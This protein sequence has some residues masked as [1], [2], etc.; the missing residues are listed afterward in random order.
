VPRDWILTFAHAA[1]GRRGDVHT[2]N[3]ENEDKVETA[4]KGS[5]TPA[6]R[7]RLK[8]FV[9]F[10]L[11][12]I[13]ERVMIFEKLA[14]QMDWGPRTQA[15]YFACLLSVLKIL[16]METTHQDTLMMRRVQAAQKAAPHWDFDDDS[17][18]LSNERVRLMEGIARQTA[19][20]SPMNAALLT[21]YLAQRMG[22]VIKLELQNIVSIAPDNI[23][24]TFKEG[25]TVGR[26]GPY[27]LMVKDLSPAGVILLNIAR[28][29]R[30]DGLSTGKIFF[31]HSEETFKKQLGKVDVRALRRTGLMKLGSVGASQEEMLHVS[32][33]SSV[34]MLNLYLHNG[35][36]NMKINLSTAEKL[37]EAMVTPLPF[38]GKLCEATNCTE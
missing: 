9:P 29:A 25:K 35:L 28:K 27:T 21:L 3:Q 26:K 38:F 1:K 36:F 12:P 17:Q 6:H 5:F 2:R 30:E 19:V 16:G 8:R 18:V 31:E 22:D 10:A 4:T 14:D 20:N 24:V 7:E 13:E 23:A 11:A 32:R 34:E 15:T 33:H 37:G